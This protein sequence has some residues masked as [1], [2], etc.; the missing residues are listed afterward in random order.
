MHGVTPGLD[1]TL[2]Y[3]TFP[4]LIAALGYLALLLLF[5]ERIPPNP[6]FGSRTARTRAD[7]RF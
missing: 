4:L 2:M 6:L 1:N 3:S 7:P 5:T